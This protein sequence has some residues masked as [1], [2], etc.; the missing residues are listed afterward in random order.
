MLQSVAQEASSVE[1]RE[2]GAPEA[3]HSDRPPI[4]TYPEFLAKPERPPPLVTTSR[5]LGALNAVAGLTAVIYGTSKFVVTPMVESLTEARVDLHDTTSS[6]LSGIVNK[7]EK[8]VSEVPPTKKPLTA[9]DASDTSDPSEMFHRDVGTQTL[10]VQALPSSKSASVASL[11]GVSQSQR[12]AERLATLT[13]T[14]SGLKDGYRSES[15]DLQ[16]LK[17]L[18]DVF[19][20]DLDAMTFGN[21]ADFVGGY[22]VYNKRKKDPDDELRR[23]RDNVR[24]IKGL[25]L[26][27]R[28]FPASTR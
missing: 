8:T 25:L 6:K 28:S 16:D 27:S 21:Q 15:E 4:V 23:V 13:K 17:T 24:R 18:V 2:H 20:D 10:P 19:R 9:D 12:Q 14:L 3:K 5:L 1:K 22:D 11:S 26:S 7:L